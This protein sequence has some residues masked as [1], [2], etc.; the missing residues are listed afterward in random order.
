MWV[1]TCDFAADFG[2]RPLSDLITLRAAVLNAGG[3]RLL[4]LLVSAFDAALCESIA[5]ILVGA[6]G[7]TVR[8]DA[9]VVVMVLFVAVPDAVAENVEMVM[10]IAGFD[11]VVIVAFDDGTLDV[12]S[13]DAFGVF[14]KIDSVG[15]GDDFTFDAFG[16]CVTAFALTKSV[17]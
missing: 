5:A 6:A 10:V 8:V 9:V 3:V 12:A 7:E 2:K 14:A 1:S 16:D 13:D 17:D 15:F 4:L 11:V